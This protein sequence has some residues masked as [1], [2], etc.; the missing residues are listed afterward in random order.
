MSYLRYHFIITK[1]LSSFTSLLLS[2]PHCFH[3]QFEPNQ[4]VYATRGL[5]AGLEAIVHAFR[6]ILKPTNEPD[7]WSWSYFVHF[8]GWSHRHDD[9][10]DEEDLQKVTP[11]T[12]AWA[13]RTRKEARERTSS[14][15]P[16]KHTST[17][18]A[19]VSRKREREAESPK[20]RRWR[21]HRCNELNDPDH[22]KC[23][24]QGWKGGKMPTK[25]FQD[26]SAGT[27][28]ANRK[29][30]REVESPKRRRWRCQRCEELN[31]PN[32]SK[33][34]ECK[35]WK[36]GKMPRKDDCS[37]S[38][39]APGNFC[40]TDGCSRFRQAN[41]D[42]MCTSHFR[43]SQEAD[44]SSER[45]TGPTSSKKCAIV[46]CNKC[47]QTN[48]DGM[49]RSHYREAQ[50]ELDESSENL[51]LTSSDDSAKEWSCHLCAKQNHTEL[52]RCN[53]CKA[54]RLCF[55]AGCTK[56]RQRDCDGMC[57]SHFNEAQEANKSSDESDSD[58]DV[59]GA[60]N[61]TAGSRSNQEHSIGDNELGSN[62]SAAADAKMSFRTSVASLDPTSTGEARKDEGIESAVK[63][64][65]TKKSEN[66]DHA[67]TDSAA[68]ASNVVTSTSVAT[69]SE[70]NE[71][72]ASAAKTTA[73]IRGA[74]NLQN[75]VDLL[76]DEDDDDDDNPFGYFGME[77]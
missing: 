6:P 76:C 38:P 27:T 56:R 53:G 11:S 45:E 61:A 32:H 64:T 43:E 50:E 74:S 57:T 1:F 28:I 70:E 25:H 41:C 72:D 44:E 54:W 75:I 51:A 10:V 34:S 63:L 26:T 42:H 39:P 19:S 30:E 59:E 65:E 55:V 36:G 40:V 13:E 29:G 46:G 18:I 58:D 3:H 12:T 17:S 67:G 49:C 48:C 66:S 23:S 73:I 21:C 71:M 4:H 2:S 14:P 16:I 62:E 7:G 60:S 20:R 52:I 33:C 77:L 22:S 9:W 47:K 31:D 24:C 69:K 15:K 35:G 68:S 8:V 5:S 37:K